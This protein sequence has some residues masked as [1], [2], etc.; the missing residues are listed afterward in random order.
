[1][2]RSQT[3][4]CTQ[5]NA[6]T[7]QALAAFG[8]AERDRSY[9][10]PA[11][12]ARAGAIVRESTSL[13]TSERTDLLRSIDAASTVES[14]RELAA[15]LEP[16]SPPRSNELA[17]RTDRPASMLPRESIPHPEPRRSDPQVEAEL[18]LDLAAAKAE[19][20]AVARAAAEVGIDA[21]AM[22]EAAQLIAS[23]E[24]LTSRGDAER[25]RDALRRACE[26]TA[27]VD[28]QVLDAVSA[29]ECR[30]RTI[31]AVVDALETLGYCAE[32]IT[33]DGDEIRVLAV[34]ADGREAEVG[35]AGRGDPAQVDATFTDRGHA[36]GPG[37]PGADEICEP[38]VRDAY[39]FHRI[40][41]TYDGL[42]ADRPLAAGRP[43]R[44]AS[45]PTS[46]TT[47]TRSA[48]P[49]AGSLTPA[50]RSQQQRSTA[51]RRKAR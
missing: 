20:E 4:R 45:T 47:P 40:L 49:P 1:M 48:A 39:R 44:S 43:T 32:T 28:E 37:A 31:E 24:R 17:S 34:A 19:H 6:A 7:R 11:L 46:S 29:A 25:A 50:Q 2:S 13:S 14:L 9:V 38:A 8:R 26:L 35:I 15:R 3:F 42:D 10:I 36:V 18:R 30:K 12:R 41:G 21:P 23:A 5:L 51:A 33:E 16:A 22:S 27:Q